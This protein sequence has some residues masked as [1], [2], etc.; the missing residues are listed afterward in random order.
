MTE[1]RKL[2]RG[3]IF[4]NL[5]A[6]WQTFFVYFRTSGRYC[7]GVQ[8]VKVNGKYTVQNS[9]YYKQDL[10]NDEEHFPLVGSMDIE[11]MWLSRVLK[12]LS[13]NSYELIDKHYDADGHRLVLGEVAE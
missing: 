13:V 10:K 2:K 3:Q 9:Q 6:G 11:A 4:L 12:R 1:P 8:I 5:W 7:Y